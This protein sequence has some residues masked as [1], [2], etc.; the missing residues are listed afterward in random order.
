MPLEPALALGE[1]PPLRRSICPSIAE[2]GVV[3]TFV[4]RMRMVG[5]SVTQAKQN[6]VQGLCCSDR[7]LGYAELI[8][9]ETRD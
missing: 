4:P 8:I 7:R 3:L 1:Q 5:A 9:G 2:R 6:R